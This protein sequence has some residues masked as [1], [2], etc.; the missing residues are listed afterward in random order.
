M[1]HYL[2]RIEH[3]D[4]HIVMFRRGDALSESVQRT[5]QARFKIIGRNGYVTKS[6]RTKKYE[7]AYAAAKSMFFR[8]QQMINDN[9]SISDH[10]FVRAL[11]CVRRIR[12]LLL[13]F[14]SSID[15]CRVS[16]QS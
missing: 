4:G 15:F 13:V 16:T 12:L 14:V 5:W 3:F 8:L 6:L 10:S 9:A 11:S 7:D 2:E 1:K